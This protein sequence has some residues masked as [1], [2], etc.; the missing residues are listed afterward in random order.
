MV[1]ETRQKSLIPLRPDESYGPAMA[2]LTDPQKR[3]VIAMLETGAQNV[4]NAAIMAGYSPNSAQ[5]YGSRLQH[6][7]AVQLAMREEAEKRL[8][9][10]ALLGASVMIEIASNSQHKDRFKAADRLLGA[11]GLAVESVSR[12]IIEDH[13]TDSELTEFIRAIAQRN[14]LDPAKLLGKGEV[15]DAEFSEIDPRDRSEE[16]EGSME[17]L[18]D[19]L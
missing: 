8:R 13:R 16:I 18:E 6:I 10:G 9:A 1:V 3:F 12:H 11:A 4:T 15:V 17:G 7:P 5:Q 19:L 2:A 14:G